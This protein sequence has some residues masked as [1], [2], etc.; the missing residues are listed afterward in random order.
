MAG[1]TLCVIA[2]RQ[3]FTSLC[4]E[5]SVG[6]RHLPVEKPIHGLVSRV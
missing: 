1:G 4:V 6:S 2:V 5:A 3:P